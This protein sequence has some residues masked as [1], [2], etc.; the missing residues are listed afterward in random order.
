MVQELIEAGGRQP[1]N[2]GRRLGLLA[3][4]RMQAACRPYDSEIFF[5]VRSPN[6]NKDT[7][8]AKAVCRKCP[9]REECLQAAMDGREKIGIWGGLTPEERGR[10]HRRGRRAASAASQ[11]LNGATVPT[12]PPAPVRDDERAGYPTREQIR[13]GVAAGWLRIDTLTPTAGEPRQA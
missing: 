6:R 4:W 1:A 2:A 11:P 3:D 7:A 12:P 9:V 5:P 10:L 13:R 8:K